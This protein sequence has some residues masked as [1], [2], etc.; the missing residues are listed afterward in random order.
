MCSV[1]SYWDLIYIIN[2][3]VYSGYGVGIVQGNRDLSRE[4]SR[5]TQVHPR[6]LGCLEIGSILR[7]AI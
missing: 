2:V 6:L 3:A 4:S 5:A 7:E 1:V